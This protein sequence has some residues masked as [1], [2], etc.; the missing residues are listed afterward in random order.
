MLGKSEAESRGRKRERGIKEQ[1][2]EEAV[3][4]IGEWDIERVKTQR[5]CGKYRNMLM[6]EVV[7][8]IINNKRN[9]EIREEAGGEK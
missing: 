5:G 4:E 8:E 1:L 9:A 3:I 6:C 7:A 2:A